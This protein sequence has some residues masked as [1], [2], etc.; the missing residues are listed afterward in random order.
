MA[1]RTIHV[2]ATWET[3]HDIEVPED[4]EFTPGELNGEIADAINESGT[5]WHTLLDWE[6][7]SDG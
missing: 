1:K 2:V 5:P 3:E 4:V 7:V 6:V